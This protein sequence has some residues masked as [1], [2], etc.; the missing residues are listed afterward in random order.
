VPPGPEQDAGTAPYWAA[1]LIR[2]LDDLR[3]GSYERAK[4]RT[5]REAVFRTAVELISG[6]VLA[7]LQAVNFLLLDDH[8]TVAFSGVAPDGDDGLVATWELSWPEQ[9][10][11]PGRLQPGPVLPVQVRAIFPRGWTHGHLRGQRLG[12]W[13][14]QVTTAADVAELKPLVGAIIAAELHEVVYES[15]STWQV[16]VGYLQKAGNLGSRRL[17]DLGTPGS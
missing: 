3:T 8:G 5:E 14:M 13:P 16:V 11:S 15:A 4:T 1:Q 10:M 6:T 12:N 2:H 7:A 17:A 9:Q